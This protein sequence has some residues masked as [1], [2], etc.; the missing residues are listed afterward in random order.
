MDSLDELKAAWD[1]DVEPLLDVLDMAAKAGKAVG[2]LVPLQPDILLWLVDGLRKNYASYVSAVE[3][4]EAV[5][6]L[7]VEQ[8]AMAASNQGSGVGLCQN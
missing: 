3:M 6:A 1:K 4:I 5:E 7:A 8:R 2:K